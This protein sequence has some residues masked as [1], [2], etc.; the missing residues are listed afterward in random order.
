MRLKRRD[1]DRYV[2]QVYIGSKDGKRQYKNFYGATQNEASEKANAFK[3]AIGKGLD[4]DQMGNT[5]HMIAQSYLITKKA[6]GVGASWANTLN[7]HVNHLQPLWQ[8]EADKV[9]ALHIQ[10]ILNQL[11]DWHD[12]KPPLSHKT[13]GQILGTCSAIF[14]LAIPETVQYNPCDKVKIP[15]GKP[16]EKRDALTEKQ[17]HWV[18]DTPHRAQR[19]AMLMMYSGLRR[20]E[21]TA[22]TWGDI[23]L[24]QGLIRVNKSIDCMNHKVKLPKTASGLRT[25][26]IP[27]IL[28]DFLKAARANESPLCLYVL[29]SVDGK[30]LTDQAWRKLWS[31]YMADLNSLYGHN[32]ASKFRPGGLPLVVDTF[33]PHQLRHTFC[34]LLYSAGV[35]VLTARDQMGHSSIQTTLNIYTHLD[36]KYKRN[37]MDKLNSY[38]TCKSDA[39]QAF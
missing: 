21:A 28:I 4:P 1:D 38:L 6:E 3:L 2:R 12:G 15:A 33:T 20:G 29:H 39:S 30:M 8:M 23:D 31:S 34:T 10:T 19:A 27:Q 18:L 37:S 9:R 11:A 5:F 16:S 36:K 26:H 13:L 25:V 7:V 35:D 22:L 32:G 14:K 24:E 17:Q